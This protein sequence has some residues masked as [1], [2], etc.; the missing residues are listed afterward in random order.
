MFHCSLCGYWNTQE[1]HPIYQEIHIGMNNASDMKYVY[2]VIWI[3]GAWGMDFV[4]SSPLFSWC[5]TSIDIVKWRKTNDYENFDKGMI[6]VKIL[7][8]GGAVEKRGEEETKYMP[9]APVPLPISW[10]EMR[11]VKIPW[12]FNLPYRGS[13]FNKGGQNIIWHRSFLHSWPITG[14]VIRLT[15]RVPLVEQEQLTFPRAPKFSP[16]F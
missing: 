14:F 11:G 8:K 5:M 7:K 16:G 12:G 4:S 2:D 15:R 10:L 13:V 1:Y 6:Y 3:T 9:H